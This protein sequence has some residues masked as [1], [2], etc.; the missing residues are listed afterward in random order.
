MNFAYL[1]TGEGLE[2]SARQTRQVWAE[3]DNDP[4]SGVEKAR[5]AYEGITGTEL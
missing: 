4:D 3:Y 2:N 5:A 1:D